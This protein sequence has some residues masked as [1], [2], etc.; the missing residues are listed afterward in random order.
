MAIKILVVEDSEK[1]L[2]DAQEYSG[3]LSNCEVDFATNLA[4]AMELLRQ[5]NYDG[6]ISDVFFPEESG[7]SAET[8][9]NAII[10][11]NALVALGIHH[12]FNTS[13][14]HH[15]SRIRDFAWKTP[16]AVHNDNKYHFFT[17]GMLIEA[18]P[19]NG[20]AEKDMKQWQAA[21]RYI[22]LVKALLEIPDKARQ[23]ELVKCGGFPYGDYGKLT[24]QLEDWSQSMP[25]VAEVFRK[26][27][28]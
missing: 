27:N 22:L 23:A 26:Y 7:A 8:F 16:R 13:M 18:Y 28:A 6:V 20:E 25:F 19:E 11:S 1:H 4:D 10:F 21:F 12:V 5:K 17:T 15:G 9:E 24:K 14:N 2:H 3:G